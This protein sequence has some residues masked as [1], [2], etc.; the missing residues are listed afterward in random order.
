MGLSRGYERSYL[1]CWAIPSS[2]DWATRNLLPWSFLPLPLCPLDSIKRKRFQMHYHCIGVLF[3]QRHG[4][5]RVIDFFYTFCD[6]ALELSTV[7]KAFTLFDC[8][9]YLFVFLYLI[10]KLSCSYAEQYKS[11]SRAF[12]EH[13]LCARHCA[14]HELSHSVLTATLWGRAHY[15]SHFTDEETD[16]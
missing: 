8:L 15:H 4:Q 13:V 12:I 2:K 14:S 10:L 16:S 6:R 1:R 5:W 7:W 9:L 11:K 3:Q